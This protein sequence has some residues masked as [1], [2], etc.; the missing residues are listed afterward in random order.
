MGFVSLSPSMH[1]MPETLDA[2][3]ALNPARAAAN[4]WPRDA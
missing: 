2:V 4:S 3:K 1:H